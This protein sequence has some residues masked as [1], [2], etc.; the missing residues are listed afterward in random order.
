MLPPFKFSAR[1]LKRHL[2]LSLDQKHAVTIQIS[3]MTSHLMLL[4]IDEVI[5]NKTNMHCTFGAF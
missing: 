5:D 2:E 3:S 1:N 4:K